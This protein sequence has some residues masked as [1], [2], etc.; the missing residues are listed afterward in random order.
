SA[1]ALL[2]RVYL[3]MGDWTNTIE[4]A[5]Y[6]IKNSS[7]SMYGGTY[8]DIFSKGEES[9][10]QLHYTTSENLASSSLHSAYGTVD[11]GVRDSD[12]YGDGIG[13]GDAQLSVTED[14]VNLID[15]KNDIRF[16]ALRKVHYNGQNLW[17]TT[18]F[19]SW[20]GTFGLDD[21]PLLRI[22]EI[23]LNRAE[24]YAHKE[25]YT[26]ARADVNA[27]RNKRG[28]G[29]ATAVNSQLLTEILLQRRIELAFEGHR[30]FDMKRLGM[31]ITRPNGLATVPYDDY[32][33]VAPISTS[34][35]DVNKALVNNPGY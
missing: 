20:G 23:Y 2:S 26:N 34:E 33:V 16:T 32:R 12:G 11:D 10:W 25:D 27:L 29:D 17:W 31:D 7:V 19:N 14:F 24:A 15:Q 22:S 13:A 6:V 4:A 21:V 3:Y 5:T 9:L 30:F 18:K 1:K 35:L 8:T 28:I